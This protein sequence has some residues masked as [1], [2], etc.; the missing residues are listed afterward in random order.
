MPLIEAF[1]ALALTMLSLAM[2]STLFVEVVHRCLK[3]RAKD[4]AKMLGE[5][6]DEELKPHVE[7]ELQ[8]ADEALKEHRHKFLEKLTRTR[9]S[10]DGSD[11]PVVALST[12]DLLK[13]LANTDLGKRVKEK[14]EEEIDEFVDSVASTYDEIGAAATELFARKSQRI[15]TIAGFVVAIG[16]NVNAIMLFQSYL[17]DPAS[18]AVAVARAEQIM[19]KYDDA[20]ENPA[21][22]AKNLEASI[23]ALKA[24]VEALKGLGVTVGWTDDKAPLAQENE[25]LPR[26]LDVV[27]WLTGVLG[28]GWLIGLGGPFWFDVVRRL[29][30][31]LQIARGLTTN[32]GSTDEANDPATP[33]ADLGK[34]ARDAFK[35]TGGLP[36]DV[37]KKAARQ[38]TVEMAKTVNTAANLLTG[39][40]VAVGDPPGESA[41][42]M[43]DVTNATL[44]SMLNTAEET[45]RKLAE[46]VKDGVAQAKRD[47]APPAGA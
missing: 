19:E 22:E 35:V 18:R 37:K 13:R 8:K 47:E 17:D 20:L 28:T 5:F 14:A 16:L 31:A 40:R 25:A 36:G 6:Y 21:P 12:V 23:S 30:E 11:E 4:F 32:S 33:P 38:A 9:L 46:E 10:P 26:W 42:S 41:A 27:F 43:L 2:I 39:A 44:K 1:L 34:L 45:V 7:T 15:S 24:E 3:T 29:S